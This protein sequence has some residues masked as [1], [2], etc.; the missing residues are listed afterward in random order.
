MEKR[1]QNNYTEGKKKVL[2]RNIYSLITLSTRLTYTALES[3]LGLCG[4]KQATNP[5]S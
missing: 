5:M 3:N 4:K 2:G 1:G